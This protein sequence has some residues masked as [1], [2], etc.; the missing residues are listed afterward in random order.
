MNSECN[1]CE[2]LFSCKYIAVVY[3]KDLGLWF[4]VNGVLW[5]AICNDYLCSFI[6]VLLYYD[7]YFQVSDLWFMMKEVLWVQCKTITYLSVYILLWYILV[8][9]IYNLYRV[10]SYEYKLE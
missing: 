5:S 4:V 8:P 10:K 2:C 1:L 9:W 6:N 7:M 3:L